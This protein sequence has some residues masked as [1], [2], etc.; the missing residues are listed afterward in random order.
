MCCTLVRIW[1]STLMKPPSVTAT[2]ALSAAIFFPLGV[3]P[4]ACSLADYSATRC[5]W[6]RNQAHAQ[7]IAN[8][9]NGVEP[10]L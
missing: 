1:M 10:G 2:P 3:R 6:L 8:P 9:V 7:R 4:T 5:D